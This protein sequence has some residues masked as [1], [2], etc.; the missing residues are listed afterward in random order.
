MKEKLNSK[1]AKE[2]AIFCKENY[3]A[4]PDD[5]SDAHELANHIEMR[6]SLRNKRIK[7]LKSIDIPEYTSK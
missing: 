2:W 7:Y 5:V 1:P 3:N 6:D 4:D